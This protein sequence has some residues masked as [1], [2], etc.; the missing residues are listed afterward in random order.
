M[1][2]QAQREGFP[3]RSSLEPYRER[4]DWFITLPH[5]DASLVLLP[6][7][8]AWWVVPPGVALSFQGLYYNL[9]LLLS[10]FWLLRNL[11]VGIGLA[12]ATGV[13]IGRASGRERVCQYV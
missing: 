6:N 4:L 7:Q 10:V 3:A 12:V 1:L 8:L 13:E 11:K 9:L 5:A 2:K